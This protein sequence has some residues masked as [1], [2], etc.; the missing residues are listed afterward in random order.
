MLEWMKGKQL[1]NSKHK[2]V[3]LNNKRSVCIQLMDS[4]S[5]IYSLFFLQSKR[6][7]I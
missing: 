1:I 7:L 6:P 5:F 4:L 3:I 2:R